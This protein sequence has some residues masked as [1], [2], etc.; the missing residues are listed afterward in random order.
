MIR[1]SALPAL[2]VVAA[3]AV[4]GWS[5]SACGAVVELEKVVEISAAQSGYVDLGLVDGQTK[6]VPAA[7]ILIKNIGPEQLDGI[8]LSAAFWRVGEDGQKDE[9][10][11]PHLVAKDLA[12]GA[13]SQPIP[14]QANFGYTLAGARADFFQHS[15]FVDFTIKVFGKTGGR[16]AKLGEIKVDRKILAKDA[17]VPTK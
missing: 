12:A 15:G 9:L 1:R 2:V 5:Q 13:T 7:S 3:V 16:I 14:L 10:Q 6:L 17:I 4:A 11:V 8:Q